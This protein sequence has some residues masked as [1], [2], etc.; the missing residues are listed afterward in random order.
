MKNIEIRHASLHNLQ[1][2]RVKIPHNALTVITGVSGSGK[3]SLAFDTLFR[4]GQRRYLQSLSGYARQFMGKTGHSNATI[5]GLLPAIA[6]DQKTIS[7]S[8]RSTVGTLSEIYDYLR[9]LFARLGQGDTASCPQQQSLFSFNSPKGACPACKGLGVQDRIDPTLLIGDDTKTIRN[10]AFVMTTPSGYIVYSQVTMEVLNDVCTAHGFSVDIP[11]CDL[12]DAQKDVVLRGSTKLKVPFGKHTL[13]SRLKWSGITA[14]PREEGYY[15]GI[16]TIMEDILGRDRN[17]NILR[18]ARSIP[19]PACSGTRLRPE[20]LAVKFQGKSIAQLSA[21]NLRQLQS[22]LASQKLSASQKPVARPIFDDISRRLDIL[23]ELGLG[24]L[25]LNRTATTLSGGEAQRI[26]MAMQT[27]S[28]LQNVLYVLDEPSIGLHP[29]HNTAMLR[30]LRKLQQKG[31]TL[32]VVEHDEQTI[33]QADYLVDIGPLAGVHGGKLV[34]SGTKDDFFSQPLPGS[35]TQ[36]YLLNTNLPTS[37][38]RPGN[39]HFI[40]IHGATEHNLQNITVTFPLGCLTVVCGVS[41]AGKSTLIEHILATHLRQKLHHAKEIPGACEAIDG[42]EHI[43]KIIDINQ[44]P[45]GRTP[46][47]NPATYTKLFDHIR[48]LF[49]TQPLAIKRGYK[50]SRFSFNTKGGRCEACQG[51]GVQEIGMHFLD[52]V[53]IPC[54]TCGGKRFNPETLEVRYRGKTI[55]DVLELTVNQAA[56]FFSDQSKLRRIL[57]A[58]QSTGLGYI[59]LGQPSTTLSGG[60]AQRIKL[61]AEL[62]KTNT[63]NTLY[64]LDEPTTGLHSYD[65]EQ[66]LKALQKLVDA[67]NTVIIIEHHEG[68][69]ATADYIVELGPGSGDEGGK[70]VF[71]GASA[72]FFRQDASPYLQA[73]LAEPEAVDISHLPPAD[74]IRITGASTHNLRHIDLRIP[75]NSLTVITGVS[76]SGKSSLAFDTIFAEGNRRFTESISTYARRFMKQLPRPDFTRLDGLSPTIA[77]TQARGVRNPRSTVGTFCGMYDHLRLLFSR[78][79]P[80]GFSAQNFSFNHLSGACESCKGLGFHLMPDPQKF[81]SH[82]N[83]PLTGGAMKGHKTGAFYGDAKG[84]HMAIL[85]QVGAEMNIDFSVPWDALDAD[86]RH[87][88]LDGTGAKVWDVVWHYQRKNRTGKHRWQTTW[89]GLIHYI[90]EEYQRKLANGRGSEIEPLLS[91]YPCPACHGKRLKPALL[92]MAIDHKNIMDV[93]EMEIGDVKNLL[94]NWMENP[95]HP[96]AKTILL[97]ALPMLQNLIDS[98][99]GYL[100]LMR[101]TAT[102]SGGEMQR[103]R[104]ASQLGGDLCG[105]CYVLD[106][107]TVG[108]HPADTHRLIGLLK[109]LRDR[110]NTVVVVEH[111]RGVMRAADQIIDLGPGAGNEGGNVVAC[112]TVEEISRNPQS[113]TGTSLRAAPTPLKSAQPHPAPGLRIRAAAA[114]NLK[115]PDIDIPS[116]ALTTITGVSGSGKSSLLHHVI[117]ASIRQN[118]PINCRQCYWENITSMIEVTQEPLA[119]SPIS[120]VSTFTGIQHVLATLFAKTPQAAAANLKK[121]HFL[122]N[123][124]SGQCPACKGAGA[125]RVS[126][127]FLPDVWMECDSCHGKR[128]RDASLACRYKDI[129]IYQTLQMTIR[130]GIPF[131]GDQPKIAK[132]LQLLDSLGLGYLTLGQS[133]STLSGG[134]A[135]RLK[136]AVHLL[137]ASSTPTLFLLDEPTTGLHPADVEKLMTILEKLVVQQHTVIVVEHNTD[138]IRRSDWVI[139]LGPGGGNAGGFVV[140]MGAPAEIA[141]NKESLTGYS[142]LHPEGEIK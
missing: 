122:F 10:G 42:A 136:L 83:L 112:G 105:I 128:Y 43:D 14:K 41:G 48:S 116:A 45:I 75:H 71:A 22:W 35:I 52:N 1:D 64:I 101:R 76:G 59:T 16:L 69:V 130:Q 73:I 104:I 3:S 26:R 49:A 32:V 90:A 28:N 121:S 97:D 124:K 77:I 120:T 72:A 6:I 134:E 65:V 30:A 126:M 13:E 9:L 29:A 56:E 135:Q 142:L 113:L 17:D 131:F 62:G 51:A 2:L 36:R 98:G 102:L 80:G 111:D 119:S 140:A 7:A 27:L 85:Q 21:L 115:N 61:A 117:A 38:Q 31:N 40:T 100:T 23:L 12:T 66:L 89:D 139:D 103:L 5:S 94:Q 18:F 57:T 141:E 108:L 44:S 96:A 39:G 127:D 95:P 19:C 8:P 55:S 91:E 84:Q 109:A 4:E 129:S 86:A 78:C 138:V 50:K 92:A 34:Y 137:D 20:A 37:H 82:P 123:S 74:S 11:W 68:F 33:R 67:G 24:Y 47:S 53:A 87:I 107:P 46:R 54:E 79:T 63:G 70:L 125:I 58:L 114:H 118:R 81:I 133:V 88:A 99:L 132:P 60:E 15:T 25:T 110:G 106:E 93:A